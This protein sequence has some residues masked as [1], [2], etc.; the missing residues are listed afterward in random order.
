MPPAILIEAAA[1]LNEAY[2][3][4]Q[5]LQSLLAHH[6]LMGLARAAKAKSPADDARIAELDTGSSFWDDD[7]R[8]LERSRLEEIR[9]EARTAIESG[10][11]A[12]VA[13][14]SNERVAATWRIT[15]PDELKQSLQEA[16]ARLAAA[17]AIA[18]LR[19]LLL[20][21]HD[22]YGAMAYQ[23]CTTLLAQWQSIASR[24]LV[25][26]RRPSRSSGSNRQ[27]AA[28]T[29]STDGGRGQFCS[30]VRR[31]ATDNRYRPAHSGHRVCVPGG[32]GVQVRH[33]R[34]TRVTLSAALVTCAAANRNRRRM[35]YAAI[36][37]GFL[38]AAESLGRHL[39]CAL[40]A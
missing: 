15:V 30:G 16:S 33:A 10:N 38:V 36:I 21:L 19:Q 27:L 37:A 7:I 31:V 35:I 3:A 26:T 13:V 11:A 2:A 34:G 32:A 12:T 8:T 1:A 28:G 40:V 14:L 4:E 17:K 20:K 29:E 39:P 9:S 6:R 5:P 23:E 24:N 18:E 25:V 22:A